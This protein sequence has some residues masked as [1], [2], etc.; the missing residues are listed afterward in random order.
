MKDP[1]EYT[2]GLHKF[3]FCKF[4]NDL[5]EDISKI[6]SYVKEIKELKNAKS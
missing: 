6:E 2:G 5:N 1:I 3:Y 4:I